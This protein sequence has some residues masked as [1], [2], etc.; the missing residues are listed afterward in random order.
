VCDRCGVELYQRDDDKPDTILKRIEVYE[1]QTAPLIAFYRRRGLLTELDGNLEV[2]E[3]Q[4]A[5][6]EALDELSD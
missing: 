4:A 6:R 1:K 2:E 3:G 5:I